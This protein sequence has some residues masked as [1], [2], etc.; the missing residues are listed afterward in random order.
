MERKRGKCWKSLI[1]EGKLRVFL[2]VIWV[3]WKQ[4]VCSIT[5]PCSSTF[6][7]LFMTSFLSDILLPFPNSNDFY[8]YKY[9]YT[10]TD[11]HIHTYTYIHIDI[12][13]SKF[14]SR[15]G[16]AFYLFNFFNNSYLE[17]VFGNNANHFILTC[18]TH[19]G[20]VFS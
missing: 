6:Y 17:D 3:K 18:W 19:I 16:A 14:V 8:K 1:F 12:Y 4:S 20:D 7:S 10:Y 5:L 13:T 2:S 15:N 9:I 11:T